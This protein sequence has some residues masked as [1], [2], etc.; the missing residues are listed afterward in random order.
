MVIDKT[1]HILITSIPSWNQKTGSN[2]FSNL[3]D[4]F[5]SEQLANIYISGD[6]PDSTVCSRYFHIDEMAVAKSVLNRRIHTGS[7]VSVSKPLCRIDSIARSKH[8]KRLH[9][10]LWLRELA[11]KFGCWKSKELMD[12]LSI[13]NPDVLVFPIESYPYFNRLNRFIID[14]CRPTKVIGYL[15]DDNFTY[16][17]HPYSLVAKIERYFL[18]KQVRRLI[19]SCTDVFAISSK[20]KAECDAEFGV[21]SIVL[22]KPI[23]KHDSFAEYNVGRPIRILYTGKL[24]VGREQTVAKIAKAIKSIN[25]DGQK[26]VLDVYTN[27][28]LATKQKT[29]IEIPGCCVLHDPVPQ[30]E[31]VSLQKNADVLLFVESLS[32][33]DLTARLSFST[34]LTD[35]FAAGKCVWAVGNRDL[36]PISYIKEENAGF[37]STDESSITGILQIFVNAPSEILEMAKNG[38]DCGVRNHNGEH[39][40]QALKDTINA[41]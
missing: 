5:R 31:V 33:K 37:V 29:Q 22:T 1:N 30:S 40:I 12:Y 16:K 19:G 38:Y 11:W 18:R 8:I 7:E 27:T 17:Q 35:Y 23:L 15:W 21:N 39:I 41:E 34:K 14:Y 28:V 9:I 3:F 13:V 4:S 26:I 32:D 24:I 36:G 25:S 10:L 2:T 20:M 6:E